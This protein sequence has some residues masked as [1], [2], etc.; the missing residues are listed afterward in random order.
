[1]CR[2]LVCRLFVCCLFAFPV[3]CGDDGNADTRGDLPIDPAYEGLADVIESE[4]QALGVPGVAALLIVGGQVVFA[5]GF[6]QRHPTDDSLEPVASSSLF[7]IG[8]LTKML[9]AAATIAVARENQVDL[10]QSITTIVPEF[11]LSQ[12]DVADAITLRDLLTHGAGLVDYIEVDAPASEQGDEALSNV[13][14]GRLGQDGYVIA[15][16]GRMWNYSNPNYYVLG[17]A[18][19]RMSDNFYVDAMRATTLD[20]LGMSR[21]L[22][23]NDRVLAD[24]DYA[25]GKTFAGDVVAP[26]DY[27]NPWARPAGYAF[28][29]VWDLSDFAMFLLNGDDRVL[30][31]QDHAAM[32]SPQRDTEVFYGLQ[33]YGYGL[34][35][36]D[37]LVANGQLYPT[38]LIT[39]TGGIPGYSALMVIHPDSKLAFIALANADGA[40]FQQSAGYALGNFASLGTPMAAPTQ[41]LSPA[42]LA[43]F[44]GNFVDPYSVG[45]IEVE[46]VGS[47]LVVSMPDLDAAGVAY[48]PVLGPLADT[49]FALTLQGQAIPFT[50]ILDDQG[51]PEYVRTRVFVGAAEPQSFAPVRVNRVRLTTALHRERWQATP[52]MP[53]DCC[54]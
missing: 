3:A 12:P 22:F 35:V 17:L 28:S 21:T 6:G 25:W 1:M 15:P 2:L 40:V 18:L 10:D 50:F 33:H 30:D 48:E 19:E 46:L 14:T 23:H 16:P 24:G 44:V 27:D 34:F 53:M 9:T 8:S 36:S 39:H 13:L 42:R 20:P 41:D 29:S 32:Q 45:R 49:T 52:W 7:R 37:G 31:S 43:T 11:S 47:S 51:Q 5:R 4:R 38:R 54:R 26:D